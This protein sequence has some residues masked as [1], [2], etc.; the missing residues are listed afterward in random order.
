LRERTW[1]RDVEMLR[2]FS[3]PVAL[4]DELELELEYLRGDRVASSPSGT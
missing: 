4:A 3:P 1:R 2:T